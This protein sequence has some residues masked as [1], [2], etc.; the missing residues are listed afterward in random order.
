[1]APHPTTEEGDV[2]DTET[3]RRAVDLLDRG[4]TL[5]VRLTRRPRPGTLAQHTFD[6]GR[7][8]PVDTCT[9]W[10]PPHHLRR[11][12]AGD[13]GHAHTVTAY[14]RWLATNGNLL[15]ALRGLHG[16]ALGC[17]CH[18]LPCHAHVLAAAA[19]HGGTPDAVAGWLRTVD[20]AECTRAAILAVSLG[21]TY[22]PDVAEPH[23]DHDAYAPA[24]RRTT[25]PKRVTVA[26]RVSTP[27][28]LTRR[29]AAQVLGVGP[30][31]IDALR[32]AGILDAAAEHRLT[33]ASVERYAAER[34]PRHHDT[35][36]TAIRAH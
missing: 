13:H 7:L 34:R 22:D 15:R 26:R 17:W 1:M 24:P 27:D 5:V 35:A 16:R 9:P 12:E 10:A 30:T 25:T 4:G 28:A 2:T 23:R 11:T 32:K 20:V 31:R 29:D 36:G 33:R 14:A 6:T 21:T 18:P 3:I 19:H 8:L